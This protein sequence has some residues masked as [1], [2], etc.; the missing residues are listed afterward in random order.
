ML[1]Y[2]TAETLTASRLSCR[3]S[4]HRLRLAMLLLPPR[5]LFR[6]QLDDVQDYLGG[7]LDVL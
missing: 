2:V 4:C 7:L 1:Q 3:E 6:E 5:R